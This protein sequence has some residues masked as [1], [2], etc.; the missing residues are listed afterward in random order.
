M[1]DPLSQLDTSPTVLRLSPTDVSQFIR[2]EQCERYLRLRLLERAR[3]RAFLQDYG[4]QLQAIPPLLTRSGRAF[5]EEVERAAQAR[6]PVLFL[7][8][9][10]GGDRAP[11][12]AR[13]AAE[14]RALAPGAAL[15]LFQARLQVELDGWLL[16][17]DADVIRLERRED[18]A[19]HAL[20]VDM[21]SSTRTRVEHRLQIAFYQAMLAELFRAEGVSCAEIRT[22]I[23]YRGAE[24]DETTSEQEARQRE[25]ERD[26]AWRLFG[27]DA[28]L[29][30]VQDGQAYLE[31]VADLVTS[32]GSRARRVA[33]AAF[34][35]L[36]FH[37][38]YKCDGC[39][40]SEFC[41]KWSAERDD[42]SLIPHLTAGDK[43][44]LQRL[45]IGTIRELAALKEPDPS[46]EAGAKGEDLVPAPGKEALCRKVA[47]TWPVGPR[48]DELVHRA[49]RYRKWRKDPIIAANRIPSKGYGSLPYCDESQ[50][51]NLVRVYIDAQHDY[52]Q[53][54]V[55]LLGSLVV[56]REAGVP[57]RRQSVVHLTE[58]PPDTLEKERVLFVRWIEDTLRAIVTLAAPDETGARRAP[59]H[60][61]FFNS[62]EQKLLLE[63]LSR[64]LPPL[65]GAAPALYDFMTQLAAFDSPIAT[66]LDQEIRELK[67]YAITC[68]SLQAVA[69]RLRFKWDE[70][71][72]YRRLFRERL[73]DYWGKR[74]EGTDEEWYAARARFNSQIPLEHAYAAWDEL[75]GRPSKG[76]DEF[77][78]F[79]ATTAPLLRRFQ[80]RRLEALEHIANDFPGNKQ[81]EKRPFDLPDLAAFEDRARSLAQALDEFVTIERHVELHSWKNIRHAPP[82]RRVLMG[83][84][85]LVRYHEEDQPPEVAEQ[86]REN[87]RRRQLQEQY[88][89]EFRQANPEAERVTLT[90]EQREETSWSQA[91]LRL[92][93]RLATDGLECS[94]DEAL[95]LCTL[96]EGD[97]LVVYPRW[98]VDGRL[99]VKEQ[100]PFTPTPKQM[101]YG[102]RADLR[103]IELERDDS[104]KIRTGWVEIELARS[105]S[106]SDSRGFLFYSREKPLL[107]GDLYT[108]DEDP[109]NIYG[110][111][112]AKV[113][114]GL[115]AL[116]EGREKGQNILYERLADPPGPLPD[117]SPAAAAGQRRF[118]E[119][120][121]ALNEAGA[122]HPFEESK[123]DYIAGH[124]EAP[125]LLVQ[126]PPGTGKSYSTGFALFARIQGALAAD[127]DFRVLVSCKTHAATDVLLTNVLA[128]QNRLRAIAREHPALFDSYFDPR[129]LEVPLY[130]IG[131]RDTLP[132]GI[133]ALAKDDERE[134]GQPKNLKVLGEARWCVAGATPGGIYGMV[135]GRKL[136]NQPVCDCLVLD[137]AS[138]M[139]LPE[140]AM[141]A[142]PLRPDGQLIVVGDHR[143]MPP[144]VKHDWEREPRRTF[145]EYRAYES[146]FL[147]LLPLNPPIIRFEESFRLH[148]EMAEFLRREIYQQDGIAYFSRKE[149]LLEP[150]PLGDEFLRAVL[151]PEHPIAVIVHDE[152]G[153]QTSNPF[154]EA[155]I[156]PVLEALADPG[157]YGLDP[158]TGLGVVVPHRAQRAALQLD[159]PCL[160]IVDDGTGTVLRSAVDT[161]ERFQG[162]ERRVILISATES[163]PEYLLAAGEFLLDP[164]RLTVAMSR[165]RQKLVLV[166]SRSVFSLFSPDEEAFRNSQLWK[167]L[168]RRT[169]VQQLWAGE[170]EGK[171]VEVWGNM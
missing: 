32:E 157:G 167:N 163:D 100:T 118:R 121:D 52:L 162:G 40:Y 81:T 11:D 16:T 137:E 125:I 26:A 122:L 161:V 95:A 104:G 62:F 63:G 22:A 136:F 49:R 51:P 64:H 48:L 53:D 18:G 130:R 28:Y 7:S 29:Q 80:K 12:N 88:R 109:N 55:Y 65:L 112:Q 171:R 128:A 33:E 101:L 117:W 84:T 152:A 144:I 107:D 142:L 132:D 35:T 72:D 141:A 46:T 150:R 2:L 110:Y 6:G 138:Q 86:N 111:W 103:R 9:E 21:K 42:L 57:V 120:L 14:A 79:R 90:P 37:L 126:G 115:Q 159:I 96:K 158:D 4:I 123:R 94:L 74:E 168:L 139:N 10:G 119:G 151:A 131:G 83:E 127:R 148:S 69:G 124:G 149:D 66:F 147:S 156:K 61:I 58:G 20:I 3:G 47:T 78:P 145:Q 113:T 15:V 87:E 59:I 13:I 75:P 60:L 146:L 98:T 41:M 67:N 114:E 97:R 135:K 140:A 164:R 24:A 116:V 8:Q 36:P 169:C 70:P 50:N 92:R 1:Q 5:E 44:A 54:R 105:M 77:A 31:A 155:L 71:E 27:V 85:L 102:T 89:E 25:E 34:D 153:S 129:L 170:R 99:P 82:E 38:S 23:L 165:A 30:I 108:L 91:G 17:G 43:S 133:I 154:E 73:F 19:L 93:L 143:Q 166:A 56:A 45:G 68:Q 160:S 39:L 106:A 76:R 134:K